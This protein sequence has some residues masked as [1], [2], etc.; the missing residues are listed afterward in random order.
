MV[1][2]QL[3]GPVEVNFD[4]EPVPLGGSKPRALLAA[5]LLEPG[6]VVST[7]R[8]IDI[9]WDDDPPDTARPLVQ[10]YVSAL[11]RALGRHRAEEVIVT[12]A[13]GYLARIPAGSLDREVFKGLVTQGRAAAAA[14]RHGEA[15]D[16][17]RAAGT[18]WRGPAMGGVTGAALAAE[19]AGLD[20]LRIS[21]LEERIAAD[22]MLGRWDELVGELTFLVGQHPTRERLRG[23]LML[24]LY[25]TGRTADALAAF[26]QARDVL[27]DELGIDPGPELTRVHE[28][29]LRS[30]PD[31]L[32]VAPGVDRPVPAPSRAEPAPPD[33]A[34]RTADREPGRTVPAQLP[35]GAAD[36]TGRTAE[37]DTLV[38]ALSGTAT[39]MTVCVIS[40]RG[41]VG[42]SALAVQVAQQL[43]ARYPDGQLH[44]E[45]RGM[46]DAP[47]TPVEVLGRFL[48]A[49]GVEAAALPQGLEDR[50]DC[51]RTLLAGRQVLVVLDD[52]A[53]EQQVRPLLPGSPTCAVVVT[54]R[55]RLPGLAGA[56]LVE[57]DTLPVHEATELLAR[58]AG[59]DR[60]GAAPGA[61]AQIVAQCGYLPLAVRIAGARLASRR[62][63]AP[64]L[65]AAR[66]ADE[67]QRLDEL[68]VGDQAVRATFEL[69][70]RALDT[71]AQ[72][73]LRRL[74]L[75]GLPD[76]PGWVAAALLDLPEAAAEQLI[77]GLV[78]ANLVD[79][80]YTDAD[81]VRYRLHDLVRLYAREQSL[82]EDTEQQRRD[83]V[84]RVL[85]GWLSL[86]RPS[87]D[88]TA[89]GGVTLRPEPWPMY[90]LRTPSALI[91][92]AWLE[93]EQ[94]ALVA[95]VE[96]AA[97]LDL[98]VAAVALA[99]TL[100]GSLFP[101]HNQLDSWHRTHE[102][103]LGAARRAGNIHGEAVLLA[104][105]GQL[106]IEQDRF[107]DAQLYLSPAL[108]MF[109][110]AGDLRGEAA[111]LLTLGAACREQGYLPEALHFLAQAEAVCRVLEDDSATGQ[112]ARLTG[113]IRVEQG[114]FEAADACFETALAAYRR[115]GNRRGE[116]LTLRTIGIGHRGSGDLTAGEQA[117]RAAL[118]IFA[119]LGDE[120][121]Q[122][123]GQRALAKVRLRQGHPDDARP[124]LEASRL[125]SRSLRDRWGEALTLR[126]L[127]EVHLVDGALSEAE[128]CF[129]EA[130]E[131]WADLAVPTFR[132]RTLRDVAVLHQARGDS[133]AAAAARAE[134][135]EIF[136]TY[137]TREFAELS[138][139]TGGVAQPL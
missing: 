139:A 126:T 11:R 46:S 124:L 61:S 81:L 85:G 123:Y 102:A 132:A 129:T 51:Y 17:F 90:H 60:I 84:G 48:R 122:A 30:D 125:V 111:T 64:E 69:S 8:L 100:C 104:G 12:R 43:A 128:R 118:A 18:L 47:A 57:L 116:G 98:D 63:W 58:I 13:P 31:L 110:D 119:E 127:G 105:V 72:A 121:L 108:G 21:V 15:A 56:S 7:D 92:R 95:S 88:Q 96:R 70:Y 29:I 106:C 32:P 52:A 40:G 89:S 27:R 14:D 120:L 35:P 54:S 103:A 79:Y 16:A 78:D 34:P 9:I 75:L 93:T 133:A 113:F 82:A 65:L 136:A 44:V 91:T 117:C 107:A 94:A 130:L 59:P 38:T 10:T 3:L 36:F 115:A 68:S 5:L 25:G 62:Q 80:S 22:L 33:P 137:G 4:G 74:G 6:R 114:D 67:Q 134:A 87:A 50:M 2:F 37:V 71:R 86:V 28:A 49:L 41:G 77:E 42:K 83:A 66:L 1:R 39:A 112:C 20:E 135:L 55:G 76:F 45:L 109:R 26:R 138:A 101:L 99:A 23:Q 131:I 24:A 19:A 97:A 73:A 53:G